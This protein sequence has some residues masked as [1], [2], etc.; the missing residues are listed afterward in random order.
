MWK[1]SPIYILLFLVLSPLHRILSLTTEY[2]LNRKMFG[3]NAFDCHQVIRYTLAELTIELESLASLLYRAVRAKKC[4]DHNLNSYESQKQ[5]EKEVTM[6][7][8]MVKFKAGKLSR[9]V[10]DECLQVFILSHYY[11][12][13]QN[14]FDNFMNLKPLIFSFYNLYLTYKMKN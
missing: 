3:T 12:I 5:L 10:T 6:L 11:I 8:S 1:K 2:A 13:F 7:A 9:R 4:A 14:L